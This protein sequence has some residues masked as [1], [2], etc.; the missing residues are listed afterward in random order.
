MLRGQRDG[1]AKKDET[2]TS[3]FHEAVLSAGLVTKGFMLMGGRAFVSFR[4]GFSI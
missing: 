2:E 1:R 3:I 4:G